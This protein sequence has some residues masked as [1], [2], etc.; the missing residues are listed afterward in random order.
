[1]TVPAI[2]D[3]SLNLPAPGYRFTLMSMPARQWRNRLRPVRPEL[4]LLHEDVHPHH[5]P[6]CA[7]VRAHWIA[8]HRHL[9]QRA[10]E[11]AYALEVEQRILNDLIRRHAPARTLNPALTA[12]RTAAPTK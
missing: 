7:A 3:V 2:P 1:M 8:E 4:C 6:E 12:P 9:D 10:S 11:E 5:G